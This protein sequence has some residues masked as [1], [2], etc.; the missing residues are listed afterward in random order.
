MF[1]MQSLLSLSLLFAGL[2]HLSP[3]VAKDQSMGDL[4]QRQTESLVTLVSQHNYADTLAA[5][6]DAFASKGLMVF[7]V[8]DHAEAAEKAGLKMLPTQVIIY[9]KPEGGTPLMQKAPALA[10]QLPLKVLVAENADGAVHVSF[11]K[12]SFLAQSVGYDASLT[13]GLGKV[14]KLISKVVTGK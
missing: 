7:A 9:G 5:L 8:I 6:K 1:K 14:E 12:S 13:A 10:L 4:Q 2:L 11:F 3:I